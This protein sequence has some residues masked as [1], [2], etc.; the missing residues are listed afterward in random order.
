MPRKIIV[1]ER[2]LTRNNGW[3]FEASFEDRADQWGVGDTAKEALGDL[4]Q[5]HGGFQVEMPKA[6]KG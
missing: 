1:K 2:E 6:Q 5:T 4:L 3:R